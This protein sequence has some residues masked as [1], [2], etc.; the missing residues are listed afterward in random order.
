MDKKT[1][2]RLFTGAPLIVGVCLALSFGLAC[3]L[4]FPTNNG[5]VYTI[6]AFTSIMGS[7]LTPL[8]CIIS[9]IMGII[10]A[11]KL[12]KQGEKTIYLILVGIFNIVVAIVFQ[13]VWLYIFFVAGVGV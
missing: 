3:I 11:V 1:Q 4:E 12:K 5:T 2:A 8:P 13:T 6:F 9:S 10:Y 7:M